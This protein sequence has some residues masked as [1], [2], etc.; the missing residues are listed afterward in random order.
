M[1]ELKTP[2]PALDFDDEIALH[3]LI[4]TAVFDSSGYE[5]LTHEELDRLKQE[6]TILIG[7][8]EALRR[9]LLLETKVRDAAQSLSRLRSPK[10]NESSTT[11]PTSAFG[12]STSRSSHD[13][14]T[15][16]SAELN[17]SIA[18][19]LEIDSDI[20]RLEADLWVLE[21]RLLCHTSRVLATTY[22]HAERSRY[23]TSNNIRPPSLPSS[24]PNKFV[25]YPAVKPLEGFDDRS[26]YRPVNDLGEAVISH[27]EVV[28]DGPA[29]YTMGPAAYSDHPTGFQT[30]QS[31]A[32]TEALGQLQSSGLPPPQK[33]QDQSSV[34]QR[35]IALNSIV[36]AILA[37]I[38]NTPQDHPEI[39][40]GLALEASKGQAFDSNTGLS[41]F[42]LEQV[43]T[44][45]LGLQ[46]VQ[47]S[48]SRPKPTKDISSTIESDDKQLLPVWEVLLDCEKKIRDQEHAEAGRNWSEEDTE[49]LGI[50]TNRMREADLPD[51]ARPK[52]L[53]SLGGGVE[54]LIERISSLTNTSLRWAADNRELQL[55]LLEKSQQNQ[56]EIQ[57]NEVVKTDH[58]QQILGLT[59]SLSNTLNELSQISTKQDA[60]TLQ[61]KQEAV[62]LRGELDTKDQDY[63]RQIE[64]LQ[65]MLSSQK[66]D[67]ERDAKNARTSMQESFEKEIRILQEEVAKKTMALEDSLATA[68]IGDQRTRD[69]ERK[70]KDLQDAKADIE[71]KSLLDQDKLT[72]TLRAR[73]ARVGALEQTIAEITISKGESEA[74]YYKQMDSMKILD[75]TV[76]SLQEQLRDRDAQAVE[77]ASNVE[78]LRSRLLE[79]Q[80]NTSRLE[81]EVQ[82]LLKELATLADNLQA[83]KADSQR[84]INEAKQQAVAKMQVEQGRSQ[85]AMDAN[86]VVELENLSRQN[87]ELLK[88]NLALQDKISES[89]VLRGG[90]SKEGSQA[91]QEKCDRL[92]RELNE[93][94]AEYEVLMKASVDFEADKSRL[95]TQVDALQDKL[96]SVERSLADERI[97]WL[98]N[99]HSI[100]S[101]AASGNGLA[102]P[103]P[104]SGENMTMSVLRAEFKRMIR[105]MKTEHNRALRGE[106]EARR[107]L[108][109]ELRQVRRDQNDGSDSKPGL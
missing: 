80:T 40:S 48:I 96:D 6:Q 89:G 95:E 4:E 72:E 13:S 104:S 98:G 19:C 22:H 25:K 57:R 18:K 38:E 74:M 26:L 86:L 39:A 105:D 41:S 47:A 53:E 90:R 100:K 36:R 9:K 43:T 1:T 67:F 34:E 102:M 50:T 109:I 37:H 55:Q 44:L 10:Q 7:R 71:K 65:L 35:F 88:T 32:N 83:L 108:E 75:E 16:A 23:H 42:T 58:E 56:M 76:S 63:N 12:G 24:M 31:L 69:L 94:L 20:R 77:Q 103:A 97:R 29:A 15:Q 45:E 2:A 17:A 60:N 93:I 8:I 73:D 33:T 79:S 11:S 91:L 28:V 66:S 49:D 107:R 27:S 5:L 84:Q 68:D 92:Q 101:T 61:L 46:Q 87:E 54:Q 14:M 62:R 52:M 30:R 70:I 99:G 3:L 81:N 59:N 51:S 82:S 64:E 85:P 106:Q 21:R 78:E